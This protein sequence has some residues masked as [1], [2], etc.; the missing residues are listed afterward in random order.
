MILIAMMFVL[1]MYAL[2]SACIIYAGGKAAG[3]L[4]YDPTKAKKRI[5]LFWFA[6]I[7]IWLVWDLPTIPLH[8][9][10]C[11]TQAGFF[12]YK[13]PEQWLKEHPEVTREELRPL[14]GINWMGTYKSPTKFASINQIEWDAY[15]VRG[16]MVNWVN[17][18]IYYQTEYEDFENTK[19]HKLPIS[20]H[21][22]VYMDAKNGLIL[23]KSTSFSSGYASAMT[24]GG[25]TGFKEWLRNS[26][27]NGIY[28][29][30]ISESDY[31]QQLQRLGEQHD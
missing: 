13:T 12:V 8:K 18:R 7:L 9:Y 1:L 22:H 27:C 31:I 15:P 21:Q 26:G 17:R 10:Y 16:A 14:G 24:V 3:W 20:K 29:K 6:P 2:L 30:S 5:K 4:G 19:F 23:A 25:I 28:K 11:S